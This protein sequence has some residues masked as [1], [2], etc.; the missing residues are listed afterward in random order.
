MLLTLLIC[1]NIDDPP[2]FYLLFLT[3]IL[4]LELELVVPLF[5][6]TK[7]LLPVVVLIDDFIK[8]KGLASSSGYSTIVESFLR[9]LKS[10]VFGDYSWWVFNYWSSFSSATVSSG[11]RSSKMSMKLWLSSFYSSSDSLSS[12]S[13]IDWLVKSEVFF[14]LKS[15]SRSD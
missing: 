4:S 9:H 8:L 5:Y 3:C 11:K 1:P 12:L 14:N 6:L 2:L 10:L 15:S 13:S 7:L